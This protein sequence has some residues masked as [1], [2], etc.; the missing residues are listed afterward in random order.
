MGYSFQILGE[1]DLDQNNCEK[2]ETPLAMLR[3]P[4]TST[5]GRRSLSYAIVSE[6][7]KETIARNLLL[8]KSLSAAKNEQELAAVANAAL[9]AVELN[10]LP[11]ELSGVSSFLASSVAGSADKYVP[12]KTAWQNM[13]FWSFVQTEA[14]R[15]QTSPFLIGFG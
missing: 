8:L 11:A 7:P 15:E 4:L 13:D 5:L 14:R 6:S 2:E 12:D 9:P 3:K 10:K 1:H